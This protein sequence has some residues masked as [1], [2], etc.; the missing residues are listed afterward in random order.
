M[1]ALTQA[2]WFSVVAYAGTSTTPNKFNT[3]LVQVRLSS[4]P[5]LS[6]CTT[7]S[8]LVCCRACVCVCMCVCV[9][10]SVRVPVRVCVRACVCAWA[11]IR[12][13]PTTSRL[14]RLGSTA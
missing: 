12:P 3:K 9:R 11:E 5:R 2:D 6:A 1:S 10:V 7:Y 13:P 4:R 14:R 8:Q